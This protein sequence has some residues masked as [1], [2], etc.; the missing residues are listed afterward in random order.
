MQLRNSRFTRFALLFF[1]V[2]PAMGGSLFAADPTP[3]YPYPAAPEWA[4]SEWIGG[5]PGTVASNRGKVILIDFFQLWCPGC[6]QFSLPLFERWQEK[7]GSRD[8]VLIVSIHTV[9]EGLSR[10][11]P[12]KLKWFMK[13]KG[14]QHPVGIDAY[15][16]D[17]EETPI[18]MKRYRT[19][20]TPQVV[21]IDKQGNLRFSRFGRF[22]P[23]PVEA[24]IDRLLE[25]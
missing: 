21:V 1:L 14:F 13:Q 19:R 16:S 5:N 8:D 12:S 4:I 2:L 11:D 15:A 3:T 24:M 7:Y 23:A 9:F 20:G 25:E 22:D 10:Q 6:N 17:D 18:T